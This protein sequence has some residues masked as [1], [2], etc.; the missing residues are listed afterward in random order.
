MRI[1]FSEIDPLTIPGMN[2]G[3]RTMAARVRDGAKLRIVP[4]RIRPGDSIGPYM[5]ESGNDLSYVIG[6]RSLDVR[7]GKAEGASTC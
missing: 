4:T 3:A 5:Q 2:G 7:D 1:G 6:N